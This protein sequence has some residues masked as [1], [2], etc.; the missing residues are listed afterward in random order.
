MNLFVGDCGEKEY[1][2]HMP[3]FSR[4]DMTLRKKFPIGNGRR[5]FSLQIDVLN[6]FD[7]INFSHNFDP[8]GNWRVTSAYTDTNG[9]FDPGGRLGQIV[10][11]IDW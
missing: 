10:W 2:F 3:A 9:T 11:R 6:V 4:F 8:G 7:N 5:V 1:F